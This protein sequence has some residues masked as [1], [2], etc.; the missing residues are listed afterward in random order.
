MRAGGWLSLAVAAGL[1]AA[2]QSGPA[3]AA[4]GAPALGE[5]A[6]L[7]EKI[8]W[9]CRN[10]RCV[11]DPSDPRQGIIS[12]SPRPRPGCVFVQ[13]FLGNWRLRCPD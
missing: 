5:A 4:M 11:W 6:P 3:E 2:A 9:R 1:A 13:G 10:Y 8:V 12:T 7:A